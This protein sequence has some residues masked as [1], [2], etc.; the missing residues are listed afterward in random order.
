MQFFLVI[1][2]LAVTLFFVVRRIIRLTKGKGGGG[3]SCG[4]HNCPHNPQNCHKS[5]P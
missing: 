2:I 3:C 4:C 1:L 5:R